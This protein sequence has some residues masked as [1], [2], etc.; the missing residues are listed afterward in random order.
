MED[1]C[2]EVYGRV[3]WVEFWGVEDF[4]LTLDNQV[5]KMTHCAIG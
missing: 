2:K 3:I 4:F 5:N 1:Q